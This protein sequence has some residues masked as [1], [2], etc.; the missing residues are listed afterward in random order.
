MV[1]LHDSMKR[2]SC[3]LSGFVIIV[4]CETGENDR[5]AKYAP[6]CRPLEDGSHEKYRAQ[7]AAQRRGC[8]EQHELPLKKLAFN[9]DGYSGGDDP[10]E[11]NETRAVDESRVRKH[12]EFELRSQLPDLS[13]GLAAIMF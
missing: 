9:E 11:S 13:N 8:G 4:Q 10:A 2:K 3:R 5:D 6:V 7:G 12:G 1:A